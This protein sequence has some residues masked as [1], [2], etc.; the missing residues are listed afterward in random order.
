MALPALRNAATLLAAAVLAWCCLLAFGILPTVRFTRERIEVTVRPS[1]IE[2]D[3]LYVYENPWPVP[4]TQGL[5]Y[6]ILSDDL[7]PLPDSVLV[8]EADPATGEDI[9]IIPTL[10]LGRTPYY[11]VRLPAKGIRHIRVRYSQQARE[12]RGAYLLTT[13][14]PWRRPLERGEY[15]LK[16]V[17][18]RVTS[19][20]YPLDGPEA[21]SF[22]KQSFMPDKEWEF[23]WTKG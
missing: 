2:V 19:S 22:V 16:P 14:Q 5:K 8:T 21:F 10:K 3:G 13:T 17:G 4:V 20:S 7:H 11:S 1:S 23:S 15:L 18:V 6:P 12:T 9:R